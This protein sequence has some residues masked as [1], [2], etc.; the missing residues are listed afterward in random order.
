MSRSGVRSWAGWILLALVASLGISLLDSEWRGAALRTV[1]DGELAEDLKRPELWGVEY[2]FIGAHLA[3]GRGFAGPYPEVTSPTAVMPPVLPLLFGAVFA[4]TGYQTSSSFVLLQLLRA[5]VVGLGLGCLDR[6]GLELGA[7]SPRA[8]ALFR[9]LG[10]A[11][12]LVFAPRRLFHQIYDE[13]FLFGA[14][15]M[16]LLLALRLFRRG[17]RR[18]LQVVGWGVVLGAMALTQPVVAFAAGLATLAAAGRA[19]RP[20][21]LWALLVAAL[22]VAPWSIRNAVHFDSPL[23]VKSTLF[24][25]LYY[26]TLISP[27][28]IHLEE[29]VMTSG[30]HPFFP[31]AERQRALAM[32]EGAYFA[33]K[34]R[35]FV[36]SLVTQPQLY[37]AKTTYRLAYATVLFPYSRAHR[38]FFNPV[39]PTALKFALYP[40]PFMGL[41]LCWPR[42]GERRPDLLFLVVFYVAYL[43]PYVLIHFWLRYWVQLLPLHV[44]LIY[45]GYGELHAWRDGVRATTR[46]A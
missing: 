22:V 21:W 13:W 44:L 9:A 46:S 1:R 35:L 14:V 18:R 38:V 36:E 29:E 4:L 33:E 43:L 42:R 39:V 24:F 12:I 6:C 2:G 17:P 20:G 34:R 27:R 31:G 8:R 23:P 37:L 16:A 5:L 25:E 10:A 11:F 26:G 3:A 41:I 40:L 45:R 28:G 19:R 7:T 32:G 15:A 30:R